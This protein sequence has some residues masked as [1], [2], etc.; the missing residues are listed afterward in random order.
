MNKKD[1]L[2]KLAFMPCE[3]P[4]D[5]QRVFI[6]ENGKTVTLV[7]NR[8]ATVNELAVGI[9]SQVIERPLLAIFKLGPKRPETAF[10]WTLGDAK[11]ELASLNKQATL[12]FIHKP[13]FF[14]TLASN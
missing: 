7:F 2:K 13:V 11:E 9:I 1:L 10:F 3:V 14:P 5:G 4:V 12:S 6:G 8:K